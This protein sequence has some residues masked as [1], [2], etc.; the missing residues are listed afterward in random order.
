[1][2]LTSAQL[3]ALD[4]WHRQGDVVF[5]EREV[6]F[7]KASSLK[8]QNDKLREIQRLRELADAEVARAEEAEARQRAEQSARSTRELY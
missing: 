6:I 5:D 8:R 3:A 1:M 7:I 4:D 2:L